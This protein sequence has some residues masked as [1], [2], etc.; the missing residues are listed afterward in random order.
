VLALH[1]PHLQQAAVAWDSA[2][3]DVLIA[4]TDRPTGRM[5]G[6]LLCGLLMQ[7]VLRPDLP[8]KADVE[9]TFRRAIAGTA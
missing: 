8:S 1:R 6:T 4:L 9:E 7:N 2:L 3:S 5:L